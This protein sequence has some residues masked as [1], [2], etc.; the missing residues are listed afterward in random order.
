MKLNDLSIG[1]KLGAG[2]G[3]ILVF[4]MVVCV[5]SY[6][7]IEGIVKNTKG[8]IDANNLNTTL[9]Q[10][11]K[12]HIEWVNQVTA[13][14]TDDDVNTLNVETDSHLCGFGKWLYGE[15]RKAVELKIPSLAPILKK[16][17]AP[18]EKLHKSAVTINAHYKHEEYIKAKQAEE[19]TF[20]ELA[21]IAQTFTSSLM[22]AMETIIDPAKTNAEADRNIEEMVRWSEIDMEMN[23]GVIQP[24]LLLRIE[25]ASLAQKKTDIQRSACT[26]QLKTVNQGI[27]EWIEMVAGNNSL[28][29]VAENLKI[30]IQS[31]TEVMKEYQKALQ[32]ETF[33]LESMDKA[34]II[35]RQNTFP[36]LNEIQMILQAI[37]SETQ[38]QTTTEGALL[39][40]ANSTKWNVSI[41]SIVAFIIGIFLAVFVAKKITVPILSAVDFAKKISGGDL[42]QTLDINQKDEV[43]VLARSMNEMSEKLRDMFTDIAS[44]TQ[45]LT[46][47]STELS[48]ISEQMSTNSEQT[49]EKSNNVAAAAE[50]MSTNMNSVAAATE[51]TTANIQTIVSATEEMSATINEI[52]SNTAK[53]SETTSNAVEKAQEVSG[54]INE[55]EKSSTEISKVTE[56]IADISAQTNLLALN[57]TIEAARA[58]SAG[59][60]FAVVA[61]E[62]KSLAQQTDEATREISEKISGVQTIT[63]ESVTA[64]ESIVAVINEINDIVTSVA[65]AIEEQSATTQ[66]ISSNVSQAAAG[67]QEVNENVNQTSAVA[68]E[69]TR[70]ITEVNQRAEEMNAGSQQVN[71]SAE[72]LSKLAENLNEMVKRFKL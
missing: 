62:I 19:D 10:V 24:F 48:A 67:I 25:V 17:E 14:L 5:L 3:A 53:G 13:L 34:R 28:K 72:E 38:K 51:Q 18:H 70:N 12:D 39:K 40:K 9:T 60:G 2:F 6:T 68:G 35:Y 26:K 56:A 41:I 57:A 20:N 7:G 29:T 55:L 37:K 46:A 61:Q 52:A 15:E 11:E 21:K 27:T 4:L 49:A 44:G 16:I 64:I 33:A 65:T 43:G 50:E 66:E 30:Y 71:I 63:T 42:T 23:E 1:Y 59:K 22:L 58:G 36:A 8:L 32:E 47:S 31:F 54:K 45:T 69:V